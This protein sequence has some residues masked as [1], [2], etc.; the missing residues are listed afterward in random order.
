MMLDLTAPMEIKYYFHDKAG[1]GHAH[2]DGPTTTIERAREY[3]A[4]FDGNDFREKIAPAI[5]DLNKDGRNYILVIPE[6]SYSRGFGT[7][8]S[9]IKSI[10]DMMNGKPSGLGIS[11]GE[12]IRTKVAADSRPV[13]KEYLNKLSLEANKNLLHVTPLREREFATFDGS[14]SGGK[15]GDFHEEVLDV[16][17]EHLGTI[18]DKV[19]D[20]FLSIVADGLGA[21]ALASI[22]NKIAVSSNHSDAK[23]SFKNVFYTKPMRI[24]FITDNNLD[25]TDFYNYYFGGA[26]PSYVF[27]ENFLLEHAE[28][29]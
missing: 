25:S 3:A 23:A 15:F 20:G 24:D 13:I 16:L 19:S 22:V 8:N 5:K 17:D 6:M 4:G 12:T 28:Q 11:E 7:P 1:F 29:V 21:L 14:F 10:K 2:L 26:S 18:Y 27:Y 9:N